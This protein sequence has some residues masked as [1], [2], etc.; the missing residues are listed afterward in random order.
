MLDTR[1]LQL[2]CNGERA[3]PGTVPIPLSRCPQSPGSCCRCW[4]HQENK[5]PP[6]CPP[7]R[8]FGFRF[9]ARPP[10]K[11]APQ[12]T[13][14]PEIS[15]QLQKGTHWDISSPSLRLSPLDCCPSSH[16][17]RHCQSLLPQLIRAAQLQN[18]V[19]STVAPVDPP[20][21]Q[22][23]LLAAS[24]LTLPCLRRTLVFLSRVFFFKDS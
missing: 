10:F 8:H 24:A 3:A 14:P 1:S 23:S 13:S 5:A 12:S 18:P 6:S 2:H 21:G 22:A 16:P 20:A 19:R 4:W 17:S 9:P 11:T 15:S 7:Q